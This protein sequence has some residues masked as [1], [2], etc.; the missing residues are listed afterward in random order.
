MTRTRR[1]AIIGAGAAGTLVAIRLLTKAR[2]PLDVVVIN[3]TP[4]AGQGVAYST[5][6]PT[7]LLNVPAGR[8]S[9]TDDPHHFATW[10]NA[11]PGDF[12]PRASYGRYLG[13][14]LATTA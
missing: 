1:V 9:V 7:H 4:H 11:Q 13:E 14:V 6:Q 8:L 2:E 12:L 3:P 10:A 5:Q